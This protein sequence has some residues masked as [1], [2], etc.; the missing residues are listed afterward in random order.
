MAATETET[1]ASETVQTRIFLA[2][3]DEI[4]QAI[5][6]QI[7]LGI[8]SVDLVIVSDGRAAL[9]MCLGRQFDLLIFDRKMPLITGDKI[10]RHLRASRSLNSET[11]I[12]LFSASTNA[13]LREMGALCPADL[14]LSKPIKTDEFLASVR[15]LIGF[16][17]KE[18]TT[19]HPP[20]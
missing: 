13:E 9:E 12:I 10:I 19:A 8:D 2:E 16:R 7:L 4:S 14:V 1:R 6:Q 11:P 20:A 15:S 5:V 18:G 17:A 3:D